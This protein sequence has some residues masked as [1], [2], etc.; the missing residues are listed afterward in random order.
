MKEQVMTFVFKTFVLLGRPQKFL[1]G[2]KRVNMINS[3]AIWV[4]LYYTRFTREP[5]PDKF[6]RTRS[7]PTDLRTISRK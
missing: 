6:A 3:V 2:L 1:S 7:W 5:E 4:C